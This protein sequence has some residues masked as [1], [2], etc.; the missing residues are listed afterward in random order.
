M[1]LFQ[2]TFGKKKQ[3]PVA[4]LQLEKLVVDAMAMMTGELASECGKDKVHDLKEIAVNW[5]AYVK[6]AGITDE[7]LEA[8]QAENADAL[9]RAFLTFVDR[10]VCR[11]A[12]YEKYKHLKNEIISSLT[13]DHYCA[14]LTAKE[15]KKLKKKKSMPARL[16]R[17]RINAE[18]HN[19]YAESGISLRGC[20]DA[21]IYEL[22]QDGDYD[23]ALD[24]YGKTEEIINLDALPDGK[25]KSPYLDMF[26]EYYLK[27]LP[28]V[29]LFDPKICYVHT[30]PALAKRYYQNALAAR[31]PTRP[32]N[33][34]VS[35]V[36]VYKL[37]K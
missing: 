32:T 26:V 1:K 23:Y 16:V 33:D 6:E 30:C 7:M 12:T 21:G 27:L 19:I 3:A 20:A 29:Y 4:D 24:R 10:A 5:K 14:D 35:T 18:A 28:R 36:N 34:R 25:E 31:K 17:A 9:C 37:S 11:Y 8:M 15:K 22:C 13:A 2:F